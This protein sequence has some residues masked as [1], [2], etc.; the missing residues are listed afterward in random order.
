MIF[1]KNNRIRRFLRKYLFFT[2]KALYETILFIRLKLNF[3]KARTIL[4]KADTKILS[5]NE[6]FTPILPTLFTQNPYTIFEIGPGHGEIAQFIAEKEQKFRKD[7]KVASSQEIV[8]IAVEREK[9]FALKTFKR[10]KKL[11]HKLIIWADAYKVIKWMGNKSIDL[12]LILFP[13][14]WH[15]RRHHKRRPL[16]RRFFLKVYLKL[17]RQAKIIIAT[18]HADYFEFIR[19]ELDSLSS[20]YSIKSLRFDPTKYKL[21]KTHYFKKWEKLGKNFYS[22]LLTPKNVSDKTG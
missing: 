5:E 1:S 20:L 12:L 10:A 13:D 11:K 2:K 21:P 3:K 19:K 22:L 8:Y 6:L 9:R 14:P 17:K 7:H 15:K 16:T 18:D 4:Q